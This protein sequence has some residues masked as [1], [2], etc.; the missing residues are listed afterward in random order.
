[1]DALPGIIMFIVLVDNWKLKFCCNCFKKVDKH[2]YC[3][4]NLISVTNR[5]N[6]Q[7]GNK[8]VINVRYSVNIVW[9]LVNKIRY[10]VNT[11]R[12]LVNNV[13]Y[14]VNNVQYLVNSVRYLVNNVRYLEN[15]VPKEK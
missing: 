7:Q 8:M 14:L 12:D 4:C 5:Q 1:M 11:V 13:R 3:T 9:Y 15:N 10:L 2:Y 6:P